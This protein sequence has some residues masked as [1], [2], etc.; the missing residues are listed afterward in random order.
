MP[1]AIRNLRTN[2][3][4]SVRSQLPELAA[5]RSRFSAE[6][7][8]R[9]VADHGYNPPPSWTF[10][11]PVLVPAARQPTQP[12]F[13]ASL[14]VAL[15]LLAFA[16]LFCTFGARTGCLALA[17]FG[18]GHG[19]NYLF[20][21]A[22]LRLDWLA[23]LMLALCQLARG[24]SFAAGVLLGGAAMARLFPAFFLSGPA[25]LAARDV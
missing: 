18:L 1:E 20:V 4:V 19:W 25:V 7:W 22:F 10:V 2:R 11:A 6:R 3:L 13:L 21:G 17:V 23:A 5:V 16:M 24:R 15:L 9:F 8:D 14:D 12:A